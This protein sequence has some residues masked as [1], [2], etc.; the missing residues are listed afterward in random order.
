[1]DSASRIEAELEN[2]SDRIARLRGEIEVLKAW[3][4]ELHTS[5]RVI[6]RL[7]DVG[8]KH[9]FYNFSVSAPA[10][11]SISSKHTTIT[12][13]KGK[14]ALAGQALIDMIRERGDYI[15]PV[16]AVNRLREE[17]GLTIGPGKP[18]RETSDLSAALGHGKV[19]GL[20]VTRQVGW[21]LEEWGGIV[22]APG[23]SQTGKP[24]A[25]VD[26]DESLNVGDGAAISSMEE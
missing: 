6:R 2:A 20:M 21:G 12:V 8:G 10:T 4:D 22:P 11:L 24:L 9:E 19:P 5:L 26:P 13:A 1:M 16:E 23:G 7:A 17:H 14:A 25:A 3:Q 15:K 18:G